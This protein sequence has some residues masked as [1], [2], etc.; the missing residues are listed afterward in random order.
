MLSV[1]WGMLEVV[2]NSGAVRGGTGVVGWIIVAGNSM[3]NA[4][5]VHGNIVAKLGNQYDCWLVAFKSPRT[6]AR[7]IG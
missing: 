7:L 5:C 4:T 1:S 3:N 6:T 2:A